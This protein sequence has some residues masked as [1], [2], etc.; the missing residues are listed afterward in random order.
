MSSALVTLHGRESEC[1]AV[2]GLIDSAGAGGSGA[3]VVLGGP[4]LGKTALLEHAG[5][6]G[7]EITVLRATG[8]EPE[9]ELPFAGL[10]QLLSGCLRRATALPQAQAGALERALALSAGPAPEPL[11]LGAAVLALLA[12]AAP[13]VA[14]VDDVHWLDAGSL[15]ALAFAGRRL[16]AEG[17]ALLFAG[18]DAAPA[19]AGLPVLELEPLDAD[20][21]AAVLGGGLASDVRNALVAAAAGNPLALVELRDGLTGDQRRGHAPLDA[22]LHVP[23]QL[24]EVYRGR[25]DALDA[26]SK[27]PLLLA[28]VEG[29]GD[30]GLVRRAAGASDAVAG[31]DS[32]GLAEIVDGRLVWRHPL[33][34]E[35]VL[36]AAGS[37]ELRAA[38]RALSA[39]AD[40]DRAA[41]H[42]AGAAVGP[43]AAAADALAAV[44]ERAG[45]RA[46]HAEAAAA[47]ARAAELT[48]ERELWSARR[49][50]AAGAAWSA[51]QADRARLEL[52]A[53]EPI[54]DPATG[55]EAA[56]IRGAIELHRGS[57][58]RAHRLLADAAAGL[59]PIDADRALRLGVAAMEAA[60]LAGEPPE[61]PRPV[62]QARNGFLATFVAGIG[63]HFAGDIAAGASA[64]RQ[65]VGAARDLNDPQLV[66]WAGAAAFFTGDED[67]AVALHERAAVLAR[68]AGDVA[69]LPFAL[70][71]LAT[72][73][74]WNG[75]P[76]V[77][78]AEAREAH[79]LATEAGQDNLVVQ[80]DTVLA[81]VAALRGQAEE[82]R[83]LAA[84]ARAAARARGLVLAEGSAEI[85]L[86][87]LELALGAPD[88]A[89][90]RVDRL[91]H[92]PGT[93]VAHRYGTLPLLVEAA[94]RAGRRADA[95]PAAEAFAAWAEATGSGWARPLAARGLALVTDGAEAE[96]RF[97]EAVARHDAHRRPLDRA[98]TE[99]LFGEWLRRARRKAEARGPLR[100]AL[101]AF[102]DAGAVPWATRAREELRAAGESAPA[103]AGRRLDRLTP[104]ELRIARLVARGGGNRDVA[105]ALFLS[106]RTVEYHL[107]KV[108][109]K[110][111]VH[112]RAELAAVIGA[113]EDRA[114][115]G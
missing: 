59:A 87:E 83:R 98:R 85:A 53:A 91:A 71:F 18:R 48:A 103:R 77:A 75:R 20:A 109:R 67:A 63:A 21:S 70:T 56:R 3:I 106:P 30:I 78:E 50:M 97:A 26:V 100:A 102:E 95:R 41:W 38:H 81:G 6:V 82:C 13:V 61:L 57:P 36:R 31:L 27:R 15:G 89:F 93:H 105:A 68:A 88:A 28:A 84:D 14:L 107:H 11:L 17:V 12:D 23:A 8:V 2:A 108:F 64:L 58:A 96:A 112:G 86:A 115:H 65:V 32:S 51:G 72:A 4:G 16:Q 104:Q 37:E 76:A 29:T 54:A 45:G 10:H 35:S 7:A 9:A 19:L 33:A 34:R 94:V 110:L 40:P 80:V 46:A 66:L 44:A 60:S 90:R 92:G 73:H 69:V 99:L 79:T 52:D 42:R 5:A 22:P 55:A 101:E 74:L 111:G 62:G 113:E 39:V 1:R 49:V 24:Q 43:D 114:N 25:W 47:F